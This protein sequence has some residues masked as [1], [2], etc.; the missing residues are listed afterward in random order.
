MIDNN[1]LELCEYVDNSLDDYIIYNVL[2]AGS[3]NPRQYCKMC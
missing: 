3:D 1:N 2:D